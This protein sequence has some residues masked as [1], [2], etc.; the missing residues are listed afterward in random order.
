MFAFGVGPFARP[1]P[2]RVAQPSPT[3]PVVTPSAQPTATIQPSRTPIASPTSSAGPTASAGPTGTPI[4]SGN[5]TDAL[6]S[7]I[8]FEIADTCFVTASEGNIVAL[9]VCKAD[10]GDIELTYFQY[11][12]QESMFTTYEGLRLASQIEPNSGS[13]QDPATWPTENN[14]SISG[15]S[16]GRWLCTEELGQTSIYWTDDRLNILSQ[17]THTKSDHARLVEFWVSDSGPNL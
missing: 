13:C 5:V 3:A 9:A 17:A 8:P 16:A 15:Q 14:Y 11:G 7:H 1:T 10:D 4:P 6:L 12:S 2:T